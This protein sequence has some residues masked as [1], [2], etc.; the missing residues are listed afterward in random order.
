MINYF[1]DSLRR[2]VARRV[3]REYDFTV[4][5]FL[6]EKDGIVELA[7]WNNPV[8]PDVWIN[9]DM[10][11][12]FRKFIRE[13]DFVIDIGA[14]TGDTTVPMGIAAGVSGLTIG[15]DPNPLVFKIL[16]AN[17]SLN[18]DKT[19]IIPCQFAITSEEDEFFFI[20]SEAS[21]GNG[22]ISQTV[23]KKHGRYIYPEK[24]KGVNLH[25]FLGQNYEKWL[26]A[27]SFIKIDAEGYDKEIIKSI[28]LLIEKYKPVLVAECFGNSPDTDKLELF[29]V[30]AKHGYRLNYFSGFNTNALT[31]ELKERED[32]LEYK[33]TFNLYALPV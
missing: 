27:L 18:V 8:A 32:I 12:F 10:V 29:D 25:E 22:A 17:A 28:S 9:Q 23:D 20:S 33:H 15:F 1:R 26:P 2:K 14:N 4:K 21:F 16:E 5:T 24:V 13:G 6:L 3:T 31:R 30:I 19:R 7:I 11:D